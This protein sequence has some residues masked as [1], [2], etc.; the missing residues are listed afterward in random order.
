LRNFVQAARP[1]EAS[2]SD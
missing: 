2:T 1:D